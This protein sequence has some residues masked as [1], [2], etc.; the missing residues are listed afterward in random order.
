MK[1]RSLGQDLEKG[2]QTNSTEIYI[3]HRK[4]DGVNTEAMEAIARA[5][6]VHTTLV[7]YIR[8]PNINQMMIQRNLSHLEI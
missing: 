8:F 6:K 5:D 7:P 2:S 3:S 4:R 1:K